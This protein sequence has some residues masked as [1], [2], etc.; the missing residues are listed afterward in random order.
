MNLRF[1]VYDD[2]VGFR[3]EF[4]SQQYLPYFVVKKNI[5]NLP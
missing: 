5:L 2:G 4:P 1:R 3:Y